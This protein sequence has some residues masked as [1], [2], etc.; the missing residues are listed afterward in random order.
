[1]HRDDLILALERLR[2]QRNGFGRLWVDRE[3]CAYLI[4]ALR[5]NG[6]AC[7]RWPTLR[8]RIV[9]MVELIRAGLAT[10]KAERIIAGGCT[11]EVARVRITEAGRRALADG[12]WRR[13]S[14]MEGEEAVTVV[15]KHAVAAPQGRLRLANAEGFLIGE[16]ERNRFNTE[17][18]IEVYTIAIDNSVWAW[19][20]DMR[21]GK[22]MYREYRQTGLGRRYAIELTDRFKAQVGG[23]FGPLKDQRSPRRFLR[24]LLGA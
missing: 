24:F 20:K 8:L 14:Q 22:L 7:S 5:G 2:F 9:M 19:V 12:L 6:P 23:P 13:T 11:I 18:A 3:V 10:A 1:M 4:A 21:L 15:I 17:R 16:L